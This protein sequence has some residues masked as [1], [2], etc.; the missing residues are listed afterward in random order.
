[1]TSSAARAD[2]PAAAAQ[3]PAPG[4]GGGGDF[5]LV[6][7]AEIAPSQAVVAEEASA[8]SPAPSP[9]GTPFEFQAALAQLV[10]VMG[11]E[12]A[13]A[14]TALLAHGGDV[15]AAVTQLIG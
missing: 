11:F 9:P 3:P 2:A 7:V 1:M 14:K 5:E 13:A 15:R 12:E 10:G 8:P 4:G 6:D